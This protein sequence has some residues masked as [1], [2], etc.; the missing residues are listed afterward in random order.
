VIFDEVQTLPKE[1]I[2]PTLRMLRDVQQSFRTS[3][4]FC[5]A[6][7][8]AFQKR[9]GFTF[10]L[11]NIIP[12]IENPAPLFDQTKRVDYAFL[13]NLDEIKRED[14]ARLVQ[15]N[16]RSV[17]TIFNS[18]KDALQFYGEVNAANWDNMYHLSTSM[19]PHHRKVILEDIRSDLRA[20]KKIFVV[21]TQLVEAGVDFDFP[22][23]FRALAP[24]DSIIQAAGRCN[25]E[26]KLTD[27]NGQFANGQVYIFRT[28]KM[29]MPYDNTYKTSTD[30]TR[31][32]INN[33]LH[34]LSSPEI[35]SDYYNTLLK[36]F[37]NEDKAALDES[38]KN[39][40]FRNVAERY[41]IIDSPATPV[42]IKD[43]NPESQRLYKEIQYKP[44]LSQKDHR[45]MQAFTVQLYPSLVKSAGGLIQK[46]NNDAFI[47]DGEYN[48]RTGIKVDLENNDYIV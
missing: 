31:I 38:R 47:W 44:Y 43:Y 17:L 10:G 6:T 30:Y 22:V 39:L 20:G 7:M 9:I 25:R 3:F 36:N 48:A 37:I 24:L 18:K 28:E 2:K 1:S 14:L 5:T 21:S 32:F 23:V 41:K 42:F 8:P 26:G 29:G 27:Q 45:K 13:Q 33:K 12:L 15:E 16:H 35:Y 40:E 11:E 4:L 46:L 34:D 19:C